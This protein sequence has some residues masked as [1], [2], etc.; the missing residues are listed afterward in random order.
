MDKRIIKT[1]NN[2]K[3]TLV[4]MLGEKSYEEITVKQLCG[5]A[6]T[7]RITFYTHYSD[8]SEV[9]LDIFDEMY[10][11]TLDDYHALQEKNNPDGDIVLSYL[12]ILDSILDT[13]YT[14]YEFFKYT[15]KDKSPTL[16]YMYFK[17]MDDAVGQK[18]EK[19]R[20]RLNPRYCLPMTRDFICSGLRGFISAGR[21][22]GMSGDEI[23]KLAKELLGRLLETEVLRK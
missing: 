15:H 14:N 23:R 22:E 6:E 17:F 4:K 19:D 18:I 8:K 10:Q 1:K 20:D 9:V 2:I 21:S 16:N 7:S 11:K 5:R 13:Y 3:R 12:N